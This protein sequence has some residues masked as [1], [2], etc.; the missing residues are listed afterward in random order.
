VLVLAPNSDD[1]EQQ[2]M[3]RMQAAAWFGEL[4]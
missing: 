1:L 4:D 3:W 2:G